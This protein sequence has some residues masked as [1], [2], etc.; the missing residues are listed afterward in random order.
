MNELSFDT[1]ITG[2]GQ[3]LAK[4]LPGIQA[5]ME[6]MPSTRPP[7]EKNDEKKNRRLS[8]VMVLFYPNNGSVYFTLVKR[9]L[10]NGV[11]SGQI[12]LPGGQF[13]E[14]DRDFAITALRETQ[15]EIG[16]Y[17]KKIKL[18]GHLTSLYIPPSNFDV[19]PFVGYLAKPQ[20]FHI[21]PVEIDHLIEIDLRDFLNP[22]S[23]TEKIIH[24]RTGINVS[25]P[26]FYLNNEIV[27]GATAMVLN[28]LREVVLKVWSA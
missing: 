24:H 12:S 21:D 9:V 27:W 7:A 14:A 8:A 1:F 19:Y 28:E 6:M 23:K 17:S 5:Q 18:L 16:V 2:I 22:V 26:C 4:P 11:H 25:V 3:E 10:Y 20:I 13:E 15:E